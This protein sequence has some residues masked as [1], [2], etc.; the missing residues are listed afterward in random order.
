MISPPSVLLAQKRLRYKNSACQVLPF[1]QAY[2]H[3][4]KVLYPYRTIR[5]SY[6][7]F[8]RLQQ[9]GC[10]RWG[11]LDECSRGSDAVNERA[12]KVGHPSIWD[13]RLQAGHGILLPGSFFF[14]R[15]ECSKR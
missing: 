12:R 9:I 5:P 6:G 8:D 14:L 3:Y 13:C 11:R 4:E 1:R 2:A 10:A 15:P 7:R